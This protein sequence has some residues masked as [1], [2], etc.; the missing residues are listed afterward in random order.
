M[1]AF[2]GGRGLAGAVC[3]PR[4]CSPSA[5]N[6][7]GQH[8]AAWSRTRPHGAAWSSMGPHGAARSSTRPHEAACR[9]TPAT[10]RAPRPTPS[11]RAA[12]R[13]HAESGTPA[14]DPKA[15]KLTIGSATSALMAA[16]GA[17]ET[18]DTDK[19]GSLSLPEVVHL[20]NGPELR[21]AVRTMTNVEPS[22]KTEEDMRELFQKADADK[23]GELSRK[24]FLAMY[25]AVINERVKTNPLVMAE[26]LLGFLDTDRN[27]K[28]DGGELKVLLAMLGFPLALVAPIPKFIGVDYR[29]ILKAF[30]GGK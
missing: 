8:G 22:I 29:G 10:G 21:Q 27:G 11:R 19:S 3:E 2:I 15:R 20:L 16:N 4:R 7:M 18:Y 1:V 13:V 14:A 5:W 23:S 12:V 26:A 28:I 9:C 6:S 24:E 25:L 30:G 17:W